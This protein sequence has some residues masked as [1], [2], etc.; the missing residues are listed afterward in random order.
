MENLLKELAQLADDTE[1][2]DLS[3]TTDNNPGPLLS[4]GA[5]AVGVDQVALRMRPGEKLRMWKGRHAGSFNT[6]YRHSRRIVCCD[7]DGNRGGNVKINPRMS[8]ELLIEYLR[9][10]NTDKPRL[11]PLSFKQL[12]LLP[13]RFLRNR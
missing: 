2:I 8:D 6:L 4:T 1:V 13:F 3:A 10:Y 7:F 9:E 5:P 12:L 11:V